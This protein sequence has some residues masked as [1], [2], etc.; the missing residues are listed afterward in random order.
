MRQNSFMLYEGDFNEYYA[1]RVEAWHR[2]SL[3]GTE[4]KL[5]EKPYRLDGWMR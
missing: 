5:L 1:V 4:T 3:S 2:D